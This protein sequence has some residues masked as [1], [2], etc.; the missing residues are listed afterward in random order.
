MLGEKY[1]KREKE[2]QVGHLE[3]NSGQQGRWRM[4][5]QRGGRTKNS[6]MRQ[7]HRRPTQKQAGHVTRL[8]VAAEDPS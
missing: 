5:Q 1:V 8:D 7:G 6:R 2:R 3:G 4:W